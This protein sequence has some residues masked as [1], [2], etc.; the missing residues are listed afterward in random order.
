M[1]ELINEAREIVERLKRVDSNIGENEVVEAYEKAYTHL[2]SKISTLREDITAEA[3]ML[4]KE[5][6]LCP[7][8]KLTGDGIK[9]KRKIIEAMK[10]INGDKLSK[11]NAWLA[12]YGQILNMNSVNGT[13]EL[14]QI[15]EG[16]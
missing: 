7:D 1:T 9:L 10:M 16:E 4:I 11:V 13:K 8:D 2:E 5:Y 12:I 15:L 14:K 6:A 3:M